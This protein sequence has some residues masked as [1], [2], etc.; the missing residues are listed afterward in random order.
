MA[1]LLRERRLFVRGSEIRPLG[2]TEAI[3]AVVRPGRTNSIA[4]RLEALS[5]KV[6]PVGP[7]ERDK[8]FQ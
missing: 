2:H 4:S 8:L 3:S 7:P 1:E 6:L 5:L